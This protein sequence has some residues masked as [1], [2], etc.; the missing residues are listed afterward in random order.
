MGG[1]EC[2]KLPQNAS[3][4]QTKTHTHSQTDRRS[5]IHRRSE[6]LSIDTETRHTY[7][8]QIATNN[9]CCCRHIIRT[10]LRIH[11]LDANDTYEDLPC[12]H[13][14][15]H[16]HTYLIHTVYLDAAMNTHVYFHTLKISFH[17][18]T[19]TYLIH[20]DMLL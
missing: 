20:T 10:Q 15:T 5:H 18:H 3:H 7:Q 16:T 9:S 1:R 12:V 14:H 6:I 17:L 13:T 2:M 4:A 19:H 8:T 11:I